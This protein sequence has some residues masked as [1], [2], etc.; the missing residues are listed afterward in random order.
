MSYT[1]GNGSAILSGVS[2]TALT[3]EMSVLAA[4]GGKLLVPAVLDGIL[5][6][7]SRPVSVVN[8]DRLE[9]A[10]PDTL[11]ESEEIFAD[12]SD[13]G[14]LVEHAGD[15]AEAV[16]LVTDADGMWVRI[17]YAESGESLDIHA[18]D[19]ETDFGVDAEMELLGA[20]D[21]ADVARLRSLIAA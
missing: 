7:D 17:V 13:A 6:D 14:I 10:T 1:M 16:A 21:R 4:M 18:D 11:T 19:W 9:I 12:L 3:P 5:L 2:A 20:W 8:L 15:I